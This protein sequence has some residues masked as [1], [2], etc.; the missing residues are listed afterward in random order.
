MLQAVPA[1]GGAEAAGGGRRGSPQPAGSAIASAGELLHL[2]A[3]VALRSSDC[4]PPSVKM[5]DCGKN[6][7]RSLLSYWFCAS[8]AALHV[9]VWSA[10]CRANMLA[11]PGRLQQRHHMVNILTLGADSDTGGHKVAPPFPRAIRPCTCSCVHT[12]THT[13]CRPPVRPPGPAEGFP[14]AARPP[15]CI[16]S[17]LTQQSML[18]LL[19]CQRGA[20]K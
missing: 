4:Q 7:H 17:W 9:A 18:V 11:L 13:P 3:N 15:F 2:A 5:S 19:S 12:H 1:G 14:A 8:G 10:P 20:P 16:P 6:Q